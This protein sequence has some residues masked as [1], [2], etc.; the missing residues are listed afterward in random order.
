VA[1]GVSEDTKKVIQHMKQLLGIAFRAILLLI[2]FSVIGLGVNLLS[3]K[4]LPWVYVPPTEVEVDG[5]KVRLIGEKEALRFLQDPSTIFVDTRKQEHY[6]ERHV[7]GA[8]SLPANDVEERFP[9]VQPLL[10]EESRLVL[11]CYGPECED[12][13]RVADFLAPMNYRNMVIMSSGFPG[14]EEAG[15]PVE[16]SGGKASSGRETG[17]S[18]G[19]P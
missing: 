1:T 6:A 13:E 16:G 19:K 3:S 15:Y 5:L 14:W 9:L 17:K 8:V 12:A 2:V 10:P 4:P 7:K 11:Y 18:G